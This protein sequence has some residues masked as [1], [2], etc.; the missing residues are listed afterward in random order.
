MVFWS[1]LFFSIE[2]L[3]YM[4]RD[5]TR[6]DS[7]LERNHSLLLIAI[8]VLSLPWL[9]F[10]VRCNFSVLVYDSSTLEFGLLKFHFFHSYRLFA[11][12]EMQVGLRIKNTA[13][14]SLSILAFSHCLDC[15]RLWDVIST[16]VYDSSVYWWALILLAVLFRL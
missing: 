13:S 3:P 7:F 9:C 12:Q 6:N 16:L 1:F 11:R 5:V 2:L 8:G 15:A 10:L 4:L 14:Y